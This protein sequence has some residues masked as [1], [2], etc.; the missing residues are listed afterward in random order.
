MVTRIMAAVLVPTL[1]LAAVWNWADDRES[2][3]PVVTVPGGT[4]AESDVPSG[5]MTAVLSW[6]RVADAVVADEIADRRR[7]DLDEIA[8]QIAGDAC[9]V[10]DTGSEVTVANDRTVPLGPAQAVVVAAAAV[11]LLGPDHRPVTT[12]IGPAPVDGVIAGD[13]TM[14]GGGDALLG[15]SP[16][17]GAPRRDPLP[18]TPLESLAGALGAAGVVAV[19]GDVIGVADRYADIDRPQAW[20]V[21]LSEAARVGALLV[22]R[23]RIRTGPENFALDPAQGAARTLFEVLREQGIAVEGSARTAP[24]APSPGDGV[25]VLAVVHGAALGDVITGWLSGGDASVITEGWAEFTDALLMEVGV[26]VAESGTRAGGAAAVAALVDGLA[27]GD[28]A[29][30]AGWELSVDLRDGPGLDPESTASCGTLAWA[31]TVIEALDP[32]GST[33]GFAT[34]A[35]GDRLTRVTDVGAGPRARIVVAG[36]D[37][38][39]DEVTDR[40]RRLHF[41]VGAAFGVPALDDLAPDGSEVGP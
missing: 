15:T 13:I 31:V 29:T 3:Q 21:P 11:M 22:D 8:A 14:V 28:P 17:S 24:G 5:A 39:V 18:A 40:A 16:V 38:I 19:S 33:I 20:D 9:L 4:S 37:S 35:P 12:L 27:Q 7:L 30:V 23:G 41:G 6:R 26:A 2:A 25:E 32:D 10:I 34:P 36:P 1:V